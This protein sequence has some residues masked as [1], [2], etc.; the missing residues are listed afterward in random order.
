MATV[1]ID[2]TLKVLDQ[3][4]CTYISGNSAKLK[5]QPRGLDHKGDLS[6][7]TT[8][9][10]IVMVNYLKSYRDMVK[11]KNDIQYT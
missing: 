2:D 5:S 6:V 1:G 11:F 10:S 7:V 4:S 8:T 9:N 3:T